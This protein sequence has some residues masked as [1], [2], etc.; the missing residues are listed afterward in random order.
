MYIC[1][2]VCI[3]DS[4][5]CLVLSYLI[6]MFRY[7]SLAVSNFIGAGYK[8]LLDC[9]DLGCLQSE[10]A[11]ELIHVQDTLLL[12]LYVLYVFCCAML[13]CIV[14]YCT[15]LCCAVSPAD[16]DDYNDDDDDAVST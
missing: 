2:Y 13:C 9:E 5:A 8:E 7:R 3:S 15:V 6:F 4:H 11:D 14:L 12:P 10:S 1:I 16:D